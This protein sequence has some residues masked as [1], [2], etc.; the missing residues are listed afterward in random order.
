MH[1]VNIRLLKLEMYYR[2]M[3]TL[4]KCRNDAVKAWPNLAHGQFVAFLL[5]LLYAHSTGQPVCAVFVAN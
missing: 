5:A 3:V 1:P 2:Q 4:K